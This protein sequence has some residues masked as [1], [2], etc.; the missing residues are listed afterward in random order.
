MT[1]YADLPL[2]EQSI[3]TLAA[4]V[5]VT[6]FALL[7]QS[8]VVATIHIFAWQGLLLAATTALVA[9]DTGRS[10][11]LIS[12]VITL[13]LKAMFIPWLLVRQARALG[14]LRDFDA[15]IRPGITLLA[16]GALV[17]FCY[18]VVLPVKQMTESVT[19]DAVA[20]SLALVMIALLMLVTRRKAIT[21][22]VAF[23]S[24]ENGLFFAALTATH[25]MPMVVE[26]GIAFDVLV[27]AVIFGVF[28]FHIRDSIETLDVDQ[29]SRLSELDE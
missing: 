7:A 15:V 27:A 12:A 3:L 10:H 16:A 13:G 9:L 28:F 25:G 19:R 14:I 5:L 11:L 1:A 26:L 20:I 23:M 6:S 4:L 29:L 2:V 22:V 17:I 21:Q 8:R 18:S 24:L